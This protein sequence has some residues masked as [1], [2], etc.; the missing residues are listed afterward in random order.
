[1]LAV[2]VFNPQGGLET[3]VYNQETGETW[4]DYVKAYTDST[5]V[6]MTKLYDDAVANGF[7]L[8]AEVLETIDAEWE[9]PTEIAATNGYSANDY[10]G[11]YYGRGVN[12]KVFKEMYEVYYTAF[13]YAEKVAADVEITDAEIDAYYEENKADFDTVSFKYYF[14]DGTAAEGED[15]AAAMAEAKAEAEAVLD[16][17]SDATLSAANRYTHA[18]VSDSFADWLFEEG[19]VAGDRGI[20]EEETGYYVIEFVEVND[21]H[22]NTVD[23]RHILVAP[24]ADAEG[25]VSEEAW[26][27]ALVLAEKYDEEWK[28]LGGSEADFAETA[29]KYSVDSSS[30]NG[31][32]YENVYL[33]QMVAE[34][35][36]WCFDSARKAADTAIIKTQYGYHIM[37]FS[38]VAEEYYSY[39]VDSA[40]RNDRLNTTIDGLIGGVEVVDLF[41]IKFAGKHLA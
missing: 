23:V 32:L 35:E 2:Y 8:D 14:A 28:A 26:A 5:F 12:E 30:V 24:E 31:G 37:Y 4:A 21:L 15:A 10:A 3:M 6:E 25:N 13:V 36:D 17:T 40:I 38:G 20:F 22:Y 34:F 27:E 41:G 1:D 9:S 29:M 39:V 16:G 18:S 33:G 7:E 19:R 11:L